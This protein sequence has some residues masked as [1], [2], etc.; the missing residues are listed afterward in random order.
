MSIAVETLG[1]C[2]C[3]NEWTSA[4]ECC[5]YGVSLREKLCVLQM[6]QMDSVGYQRFWS[7]EGETQILNTKVQDL[8]TA[9]T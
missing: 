9:L 7:L 2:R 5:R 8:I 6:A 4:K 1:Y 3:Y